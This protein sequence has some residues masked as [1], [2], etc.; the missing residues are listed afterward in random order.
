MLI[1]HPLSLLSAN[2][3]TGAT[4]HAT[5]SQKKPYQKKFSQEKKKKDYGWYI[6]AQRYGTRLEEYSSGDGDA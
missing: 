3:K 6:F 1:S 4:G 2:D 5:T